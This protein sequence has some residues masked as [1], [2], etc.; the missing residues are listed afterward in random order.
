MCVCESVR[1]VLN[2]VDFT[3]RAGG[4]TLPYSRGTC[5]R[6]RVSYSQRGAR[7]PVSCN[8]FEI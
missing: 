2:M 5:C 7:G 4:F 3:V 8:F 6:V 1:G